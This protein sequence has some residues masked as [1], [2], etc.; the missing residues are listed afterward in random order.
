MGR[1]GR[2]QCEDARS[3]LYSSPLPSPPVY[4][5]T[6]LQRATTQINAR[7]RVDARVDTRVGATVDA[8]VDATVLQPPFLAPTTKA[9]V[10]DEEWPTIKDE[11]QDEEC[12][13]FWKS[14][15]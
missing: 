9:E 3:A 12:T 4:D 11:V 15:G 2:M 14:K 7:T 5:L 13:E 6:I 1:M 10:Q 8:R